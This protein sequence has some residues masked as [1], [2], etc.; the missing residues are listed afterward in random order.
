MTI[1]A[2]KCFSSAAAVAACLCLAATAGYANGTHPGLHRVQA[3]ALRTLSSPTGGFTIQ[4]PAGWGFRPGGN[5]DASIAVSPNG[6][7]YPNAYILALVPITGLRTDLTGVSPF[8]DT[9]GW[10][11]SY[12]GELVSPPTAAQAVQLFAAAIDRGFLSSLGLANMQT[13][14]LQST[15]ANAAQVTSRFQFRDQWIE[16]SMY[17]RLV[18]QLNPAYSAISGRPA[19]DTL[20]F[21][22][23]CSA[24]AGTLGAL[25]R[26]CARILRS[27]RAGAQWLQRD[28]INYFVNQDRQV[29]LA[30]NSVNQIGQMEAQSEAQLQDSTARVGALWRNAL[31]GTTDLVDTQSGEVYNVTDQYSYYCVSPS[32]YVLGTNDSSL[33]RT[34][35]CQTVL[36]RQGV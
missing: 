30:Q 20:A 11:R 22:S 23:G 26:T 25:T 36:R 32:Q 31:G 16:Q 9:A 1:S 35:S 5:S 12:F 13:L 18:Y 28:L 17:L 34:T 6:S 33:L 27:F 19:Y 24:P 8:A 14:S 10:L 4:A 2:T 7:A 15:A 29:Q 3:L 21:M